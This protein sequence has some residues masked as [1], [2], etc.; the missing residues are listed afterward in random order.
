MA[1][2]IKN[3]CNRNH[4]SILRIQ[5]SLS[6]H[7]VK[8]NQLTDNEKHNLCQNQNPINFN[9]QTLSI[10]SPIQRKSQLFQI[11]NNSNTLVQLK[12]KRRIRRNKLKG[13][14]YKYRNGKQGKSLKSVRMALVKLAMRHYKINTYNAELKYIHNTE[15]DRN[16]AANYTLK[17]DN[18]I[19]KTFIKFYPQLFKLPFNSFINTI[20]HEAYHVFLYN[21]GIYDVDKKRRCHK[22][23]HEFLAEAKEILGKNKENPQQFDRDAERA[24]KY[25][26]LIYK[27]PPL[28]DFRD[29]DENKLREFIKKQYDRVH[30]QVKIRCADFID[31][32]GADNRL[33]KK[34]S[35]LVKKY[36]QHRQ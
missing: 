20:R 29:I 1:Y 34:I 11:T 13:L 31:E 10:S 28:P 2:K 7:S 23:I 15:M 33:A 30:K 26:I 32:H 19:D 8:A 22:P 25:W 5:T 14:Y 18:S 6:R 24:L 4:S 35:Q 12:A 3:R 9:L 21:K 16:A 17:D 36:E 27:N